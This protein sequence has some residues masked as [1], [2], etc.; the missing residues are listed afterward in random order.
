[1]RLSLHTVETTQPLKSSRV[2]AHP[3]QQMCHC[4]SFQIILPL[5]NSLDRKSLHLQKKR[6][7]TYQV[8]LTEPQAVTD[9]WQMFGH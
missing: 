9:S 3:S 5:N 8:T 2:S 6:E 7:P 1:M 4:G